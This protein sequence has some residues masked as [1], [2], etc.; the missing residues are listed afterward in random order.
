MVVDSQSMVSWSLFAGQAHCPM[1]SQQFVPITRAFTGS[2]WAYDG[3]KLD[4]CG[5]LQCC[6]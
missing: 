5:K 2:L 3:I 6:E 1:C 4:P